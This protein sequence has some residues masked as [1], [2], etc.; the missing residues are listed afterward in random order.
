LI[1]GSK[2]HE[3]PVE[4][5][6]VVGRGEGKEKEKKKKKGKRGRFQRRGVG[7][8]KFPDCPSD[9]SY[10]KKKKKGGGGGGEKKGLP[11]DGQS[12]FF[13]TWLMSG[14]RDGK[15]EGGREKGKGSF[16]TNSLHQPGKL[17]S[18]KASASDG[19]G[20]KKGKKK[21]S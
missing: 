14:R 12:S 21:G 7:P 1:A 16:V 8:S 18:R 2:G 17:A 3:L 15:K 13:S 10:K 9:I 20:E 4:S 5:R 19:G 11:I 6:L